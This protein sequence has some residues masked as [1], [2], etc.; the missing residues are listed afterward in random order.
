MLLLSCVIVIVIAV[1]FEAVKALRS[2]LEMR[3]RL[4]AVADT[5]LA[6]TASGQHLVAEP[7]RRKFVDSIRYVPT[8]EP[9]IDV[10]DAHRSPACRMSFTGAH[11]LQTTL[12]AL[13]VLL[14]MLLMLIFM[15]YNVWLCAAMVGGAALGF[16][17]FGNVHPGVEPGSTHCH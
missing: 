7:H 2:Y 8:L 3:R 9:H 14:G 5:P 1:A 12:Y 6:S 4:H 15:T 17:F 11:L 13:Q 16:L 10:D